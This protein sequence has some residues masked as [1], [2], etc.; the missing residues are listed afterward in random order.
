MRS[1]P[2]IAFDYRPAPAIVALAG[3][4][5][6]AAASAPWL[7]AAPL[8]A[9]AVVSVA[10]AAYGIVALRRF[11][12][13]AFARIAFRASGWVLV[14]GAGIEHAATLASFARYGAW[15]AL[16][17]RLDRGGRFRA[18]VGPGNSDAEARRRLILLLSRA[19]VV[20]PG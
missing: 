17:F 4:M 1:A 3:A 2:S 6:V 15:I 10:A 12:R 7:S 18:L 14:D 20:Q 9:R 16:D 8:V 19:E 11:V 5:V 13:S